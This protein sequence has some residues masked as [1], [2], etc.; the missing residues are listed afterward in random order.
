M[1][2]KERN[3]EYR[4]LTAVRLQAFC[5]TIYFNACLSK[6]SSILNLRLV[7]G[8]SYQSCNNTQTISL[9]ADDQKRRDGELRQLAPFFIFYFVHFTMTCPLN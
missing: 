9:V 8:I 3:R 6:T 1:D 4:Y 7:I 2:W 5:R